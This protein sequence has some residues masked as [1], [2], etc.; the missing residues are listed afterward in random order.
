MFFFSEKPTTVNKAPSKPASNDGWGDLNDGGDMFAVK[1]PGDSVIDDW[2]DINPKSNDVD[3][4]GVGWDTPIATAK[5]S[6][7]P[8]IKKSGSGT[9]VGLGLQ[10]KPAIGRLNL[11][12]SGSAQSKTKKA[13]D[14]NIDALLGIAAPPPASSSVSHIP[15][16]KPNSL[17]ALMNKSTTSTNSNSGWGFDDPLPTTNS[18]ANKGWDDDGWGESMSSNVLQP[19]PVLQPTKVKD[20]KG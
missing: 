15:A 16:A 7:T 4:W 5:S 1:D 9:T 19:T 3:D 10:K 2:A 12:S 6:P 17:N 8:G 14:D 20:E 13:I 11:P 18:S